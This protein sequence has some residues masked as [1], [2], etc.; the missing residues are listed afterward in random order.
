M[1]DLQLSN[2]AFRVKEVLRGHL[3]LNLGHL[4]GPG[5]GKD[6]PI[7][8]N[9]DPTLWIFLACFSCAML[10][11]YTKKC[12]L[13]RP[14]P[15]SSMSFC[16]CFWGFLPDG[17][18][19]RLKE[20]WKSVLFGEKDGCESQAVLKENLNLQVLIPRT[21]QWQTSDSRIVPCNKSST[22]VSVCSPTS[23]LE[24][25]E[26]WLGMWNQDWGSRMTGQFQS[27]TTRERVTSTCLP[28]HPDVT[29]Q[30]EPI[31][32]S[33]TS[34]KN[35]PANARRSPWHHLLSNSFL[36]PSW[37]PGTAKP[38]PKFLRNQKL[39]VFFSDDRGS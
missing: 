21:W 37:S 7:V 11:P 6:P 29:W 2:E 5:K 24:R 35:G 8:S 19:T 38:L 9:L 14:Q 32:M 15:M 22:I 18:S 26:C 20:L 28:H 1:N 33:K 30:A 34:Q 4:R 16:W 12:M 36:P 23:Q 13:Y 31:W 25:L 3:Q 27:S 17:W 39:V 10:P